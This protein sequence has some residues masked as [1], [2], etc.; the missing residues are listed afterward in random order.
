M[1][2][3]RGAKDR[4]IINFDSSNMSLQIDFFA[5]MRDHTARLYV[6]EKKHLT[7]NGIKESNLILN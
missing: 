4:E 6:D 2:S 5:G 3:F 7:L 1:R